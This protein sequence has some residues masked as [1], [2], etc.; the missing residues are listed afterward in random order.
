MAGRLNSGP[1][2]LGQQP[3]VISM[4]APLQGQLGQ[5]S[6]P[7]TATINLKHYVTKLLKDQKKKKKKKNC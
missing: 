5:A 2:F 4:I 6:C 3:V 7:A 1:Y